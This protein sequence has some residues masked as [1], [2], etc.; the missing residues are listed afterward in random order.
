MRERS[1]TKFM[2]SRLLCPAIVFLVVLSPSLT[3][4]GAVDVVVPDTPS[5]LVVSEFVFPNPQ[6]ALPH[7]PQHNW[8]GN[9]IDTTGMG[10]PTFRATLANQG[11]LVAVPS[12]AD[13]DQTSKVLRDDLQQHLDG[14]LKD[15]KASIDQRVTDGL[16]KITQD[17]ISQEQRDKLRKEILDQVTQMIDSMKEDILAKVKHP[18]S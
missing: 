13:M 7:P 8:W 4:D 18:Q 10:Y 6:Q 12:V 11:R 3:S 16:G 17:E 2:L 5:F 15:L 14:R 9:I 1:L